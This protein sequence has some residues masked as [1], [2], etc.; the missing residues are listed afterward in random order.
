MAV[1]MV[2]MKVVKKAVQR[3]VWMVDAKA[4]MKGELTDESRVVS[5][6]ELKVA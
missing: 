6:V 2:D 5:W 3:A 4:A 1:S